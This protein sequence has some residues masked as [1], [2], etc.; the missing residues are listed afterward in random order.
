MDV[1]TQALEVQN[2]S[3]IEPLLLLL[4]C[5]NQ[6][7]CVVEDEDPSVLSGALVHIVPE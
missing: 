3:S 5:F 6:L 2:G 4:V 7:F 1:L